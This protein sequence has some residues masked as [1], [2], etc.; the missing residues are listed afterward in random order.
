MRASTDSDNNNEWFAFRVRPRHEKAVALAL[1]E[2]GCNEFLPLIRERRRWANRMRH[3]DLPLFP[4]YVF[5]Y[6]QRFG[7][8]PILTTPG[9][10]DVVRAG[11]TPI[12]A[13][14]AEIESLRSAVTNDIPM[15]RCSYLEMGRT[16]EIVEGPLT[17]M[18]GILVN[19]RKSHRLVLSVSLLCR[20]VL[21]EI[22]PKWVRPD[23]EWLVLGESAGPEPEF[24]IPC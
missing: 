14:K 10:I 22:D 15:E 4:G 5:C 24:G 2:R 17:G 13:E 19:V 23:E 11:A 3:V 16:V 7:L 8:L 18:K 1:R 6:A 9:V 12:A 20:S 21:I